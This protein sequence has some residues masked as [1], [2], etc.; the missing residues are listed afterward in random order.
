MLSVII[1]RFQTPHLHQGHL[2]LIEEAHKHGTTTLVL[3]GTT[4]ATGTD[5]NPLDFDS[6]Y[7]LFYS[8]GICSHLDIKPLPDC[9]SDKDW[10]DNIDKIIAD[11]G[12]EE[13]TIFGGRDNS[14]EN[15]Y[16]GKHPIKIINSIGTHSA[17]KLRQQCVKHP[18]KNSDFRAGIIYATENRYPIVYSTV[19]IIVKNNDKY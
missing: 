10:S 17:T 6:R 3:I 16:S 12:F 4:A 7:D 18:I 8:H 15:Y 13:A 5:K 19:D 9:P 14:V 2:Q 11:L 1:G